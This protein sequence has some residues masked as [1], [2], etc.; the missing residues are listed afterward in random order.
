MPPSFLF[1]WFQFH[2]Q[3]RGPVQ[4]FVPQPTLCPVIIWDFSIRVPRLE[5]W[6]GQLELSFLPLQQLDPLPFLP[7]LGIC[8]VLLHPPTTGH[9]PLW[10]TGVAC[11]LLAR[12]GLP[13]WGDYSLSHTTTTALLASG[14]GLPLQGVHG[15]MV[16]TPTNHIASTLVGLVPV[17]VIAL[18][19]GR[20]SGQSF[21]SLVVCSICILCFY[22]Y[23]YFTAL[24]SLPFLTFGYFMENLFSAPFWRV[25]LDFLKFIYV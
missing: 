11:N 4:V 13:L 16:G 8:V 20:L 9:L 7:P 3:T 1:M 17:C 23:S 18:S 22:D 25:S 6:T 15:G 21:C 19:S 10:E 2:V 24:L 5:Q 14:L 12:L